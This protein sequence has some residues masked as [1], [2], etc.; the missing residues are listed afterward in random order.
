MNIS[1]TK[2]DEEENYCEF[3]LEDTHLSIANALRRTMIAEIPTMAIELVTV[4]QNTSVLND[5]FIAHRLGL[6][7]LNCQ[8]VIMEDIKR[9]TECT[10]EDFC[11][12]CSVSFSLHIKNDQNDDAI[13]VTSDD[14]ISD[15]VSI[16]PFRFSQPIVIAKLAPEQEIR[17]KAI[18]VKGISKEHAKWSPVATVAMKPL[19]DVQINQHIAD[20]LSQKQ[21]EQFVNICPRKV[22]KYNHADDIIEIEDAERCVYCDECVYKA[23]AMDVKDLVVIRRSRGRHG[24]QN[25]RFRVESTGALT[26]RQIILSATRILIKKL[27]RVSE[28][29]KTAQSKLSTY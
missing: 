2:Y 11:K 7:P 13:N 19:P 16:Q 28:G 12:N 9:R 5:E 20:D 1:I 26:P 25:F 3:K 24:G 17:L 10:C 18:A 14:L 6:I 27:D 21:R 15:D 22:F 4:E 29:I 8:N 23:E